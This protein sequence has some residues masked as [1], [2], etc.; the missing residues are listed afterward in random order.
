MM[1]NK[2]L[3]F[4]CEDHF[5]YAWKLEVHGEVPSCEAGILFK[6]FGRIGCDVYWDKLGYINLPHFVAEPQSLELRQPPLKN[7]EKIN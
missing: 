6:F 7:Q 2:F 5:V 1:N 4:L 3:Q